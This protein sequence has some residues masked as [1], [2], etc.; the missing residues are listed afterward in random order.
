MNNLSSCCGLFDAKIRASDK[1]LPVKERG[2]HHTISSLPYERI[3]TMRS[4]CTEEIHTVEPRMKGNCI[5]YTWEVC[6]WFRYDT[7]SLV[8][9]VAYS[10]RAHPHS[11]NSSRRYTRDLKFLLINIA[12]LEWTLTL[13]IGPSTVNVF[14]LALW[15][16]Q[17]LLAEF[18]SVAAVAYSQRAHP[19]I[20]N[21]SKCYT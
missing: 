15:N 14:L 4:F 12:R 20:S 18:E 10:Q 17:D 7:L 9:A 3:V 11:S 21:S 19:P 1:D 6:I 5:R 2:C 13:Y 16:K 8:A